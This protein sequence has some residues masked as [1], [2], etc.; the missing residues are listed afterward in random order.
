MLV[1]YGPL[2]VDLEPLVS[3]VGSIPADRWVFRGDPESDT[4][5]VVREDSPDFPKDIVSRVLDAVTV[6]GP[7]YTN[8]VVLSCV[9]PGCEIKPHRDDFGEE[10]RSRSVHCHIPLTTHPDVIMGFPEHD[11]EA[12][13]KAGH[14]YSMDETQVHYVKNPTETRRV[15][16]LFAYWA[17]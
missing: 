6:F 9:P 17:N 5:C 7:G 1:D 3:A 16:L 12:H 4:T 2:G 11:I 10:V 14:V 8:R 13:M 15:H